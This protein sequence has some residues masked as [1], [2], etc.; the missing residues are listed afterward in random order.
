LGRDYKKYW[1]PLEQSHLYSTAV[2]L[3]L[4]IYSYGGIFIF[5]FVLWGYFILVRSAWRAARE[6]SGAAATIACFILIAFGI[7]NIFST[8]PDIL[9]LLI[10]FAAALTP[11]LIV[12][13]PN[14]DKDSTRYTTK[15]EGGKARGD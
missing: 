9:I 8:I 13:M 14:R 11:L 2:N 4:S 3:W 7:N 5:V 12:K 1:Q 15:T 6:T 10:T